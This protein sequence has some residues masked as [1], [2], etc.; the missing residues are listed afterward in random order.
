MK[1]LCLLFLLIASLFLNACTNK[2]EPRHSPLT[3]NNK[4][5]STELVG[6]I[7]KL[8]NQRA[9]VVS[10]ISREIN[11]TR[12]EFY[13]AIWVSNMPQ[14]VEVGQYVN[15]WLEGAIAASYPAQGKA[16]KVTIAKIQK[17]EKAIL[18]Q[19]E[20]IRKALLNKD[21]SSINV[22]AIKGVSY[23]ENSDIW[24]IRYKDAKISDGL[25]EEHSMQ[26]PDK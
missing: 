21:I 11:Q 18:S 12:K 8:E 20:V 13:D 1:K 2:V 5:S 16:S 23:D 15:L 6:F 17:P 25:L 14:D 7:T 19:D 22:L 3:E 4:S 26:V 9:L 10:P 24:I